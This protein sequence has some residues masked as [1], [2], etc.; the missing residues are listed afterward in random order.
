MGDYQTEGAAKSPGRGIANC[1]SLENITFPKKLT[2]MEYFAFSRCSS[3][4]NIVLPEGITDI[5]QGAFEYCTNMESIILPESLISIDV[6]VFEG[7]ERSEEIRLPSNVRDVYIDAFGNSENISL[8]D[9]EVDSRNISYSSEEGVLYN[10]EKTSLLLLCY[11]NGIKENTFTIPDSVQHIGHRAFYRH[12]YL[13]N[14]TIPQTVTDIDSIAFEGGKLKDITILNKECAFYEDEDPDFLCISSDAVIHGYP[15]STAEAYAKKYNHTFKAIE[16]Q[17]GNKTPVSDHESSKNVKVSKIKISG[18][19]HKIAVG[20][21]MTLKAEV[22]PSDA[23]NKGITW[24]SGN[25]KYVTVNSRGKVTVRKSGKTVTITAAAE[26]GSGKKATYKITPVKNRVKKIIIFGKKKV[27]AGRF[28]QLTVKVTA[29]GK[30][31]NKT[32]TWKSSNDKYAMVN[33]KGKVTAT[34]SAIYL[35]TRSV[36]SNA[37]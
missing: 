14:I 28:L 22:L 8:K 16:E 4:K 26:D 24:E 5:K 36:N 2:G 11:P 25:K 12:E 21:S 27:K 6:G 19:S 32:V 7:C 9:I 33:K 17:S 20:K 31:A 30:S 13:T 34:C 29:T 37:S 35:W 15:G 3:L 10:K 18:L 1:S 23:S